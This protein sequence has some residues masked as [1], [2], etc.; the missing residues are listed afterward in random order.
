MA[1]KTTLTI[2]IFNIISL[3]LVFK[4]LFKTYII[5]PVLNTF[6][7]FL[8]YS[9]WA[10]MELNISKIKKLF[11][12]A[13][14]TLKDKKDLDEARNAFSSLLTSSTIPKGM[15]IKDDFTGFTSFTIA[16]GEVV[17]KDVAAFY[18]HGGGFALGGRKA[19]VNFASTLSN[20]ISMETYL[21]DYSLCPETSCFNMLE[22]LYNVYIYITR[23][24]Y[25]KIIFIADG[26][27]CYLSLKLLQRLKKEFIKL[28]ERLVFISPFLDLSCSSLSMENQKKDFV[29]SP[30]SLNFFASLVLK[31]VS[32]SYSI[33]NEKK[34]F[35][36]PSYIIE[37]NLLKDETFES[38]FPPIFIQVSSSELL[39]NDSLRL[40]ELILKH[41]GKA[42]LE[43]YGDA[44]HLFQIFMEA[45]PIAY[46]ACQSL[47]C[48][49][50]SE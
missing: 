24:F 20:L 46:L 29:F 27:G 22:D 42:E 3:F 32:S 45:S 40:R 8:R 7:S 38:P 16:K 13:T 14:Y 50:K 18:I 25:K 33:E 19:Y 43:V 9:K 49:I 37:E 39:F 1:Q 21:P 4:R 31:D 34:Y 35:E 28:P 2:K 36:R 12:K 10:L 23:K 17:K 47:I 5:T 26:A 41:G 48:K 6:V 44:F 15:E 11:K 30:K